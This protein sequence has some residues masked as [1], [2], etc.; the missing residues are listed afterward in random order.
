MVNSIA[1]SNASM[2]L[3]VNQ[4][5]ITKLIVQYEINGRASSSFGNSC[6]FRRGGFGSGFGSGSSG[7]GSVVLVVVPA[8][9][10]QQWFW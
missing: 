9:W 3:I 8:V 10:F 4:L 6:G 1:N 5:R 7:S 2:K